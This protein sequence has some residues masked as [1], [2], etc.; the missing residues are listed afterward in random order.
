MR[1]YIYNFFYKKMWKKNKMDKVL[2]FQN[3]PLFLKHFYAVVIFVKIWLQGKSTSNIE[4]LSCEILDY[5]LDVERNSGK[6]FFKS[7]LNEWIEWQSMV[8]SFDK[9]KANIPFHNSYHQNYI[10]KLTFYLN[11]PSYH[12]NYILKLTFYLNLP[13]IEL[14]YSK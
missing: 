2:T 5:L 10:L 7:N 14:S 4:Y 12:Q 1:C 13:S 6:P 3:R 8:K 11:L 9:F